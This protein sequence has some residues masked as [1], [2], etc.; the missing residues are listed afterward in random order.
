MPDL[1]RQ[2]G[3]VRCKNRVVFL[4]ADEAGKVI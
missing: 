3:E 4:M 2:F 1:S